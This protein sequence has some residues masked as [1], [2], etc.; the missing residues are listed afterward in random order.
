MNSLL[1]LRSCDE[2]S[3]HLLWAEQLQRS[4]LPLQALIFVAAISCLRVS[5]ITCKNTAEV[6]ICLLQVARDTYRT[7]KTG[8]MSD[9]ASTA[10]EIAQEW[11][12]VT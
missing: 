9:L 5:Y 1:C 2:T 12:V 11:K 7:I 8:T 4:I 6:V 10:R 3:Q